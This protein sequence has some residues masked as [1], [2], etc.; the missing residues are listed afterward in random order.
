MRLGRRRQRGLQQES[1][2]GIVSFWVCRPLCTDVVTAGG[3]KQGHCFIV[4]LGLPFQTYRGNLHK[5]ARALAGNYTVTISN[6]KRL[7]SV[8][9]EIPTRFR[10]THTCCDAVFWSVT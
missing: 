9:N 1:L 4:T 3:G 6:F 10:G 2:A 8:S 7:L 5:I